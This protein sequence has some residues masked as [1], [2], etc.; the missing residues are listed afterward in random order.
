M[1]QAA[2]PS[3]RGHKRAPDISRCGLRPALRGGAAWWP[4]AR[5]SCALVLGQLQDVGGDL[6]VAQV[7]D[8]HV[9]ENAT[10]R[11]ANGN[12]DLAELLGVARIARLLGRLVLD[13]RQRPL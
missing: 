13:V 2:S 8:R 4:L 3:G 7:G 12:P 9:L 5:D 6:A 1:V 10:E 11:G